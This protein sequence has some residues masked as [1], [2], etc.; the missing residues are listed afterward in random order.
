MAFASKF[1]SPDL[2]SDVEKNTEKSKASLLGGRL[3]SSPAQ[4]WKSRIS[5]RITLAVFLTILA[6]QA[7][8]LNFT[9]KEFENE[10]LFHIK[11]IG[12]AAIV[13]LLDSTIKDLLAPP[14]S[15]R[16]VNRLLST[17][18]VNG[19]AVYSN[20]VDLIK[21]YGEPLNTGYARQRKPVQN[22]SQRRRQ[23]L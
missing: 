16:N 23:F 5:W 22:V 6:V 10:R 18:I 15:D 13:P 14:I 19:L 21:T 17:T 4:I 20:Q 1:K 7:G 9:M 12:R 3:S 2:A 11:Q 8:I